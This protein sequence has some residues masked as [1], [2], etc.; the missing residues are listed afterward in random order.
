M[1]KT[2]YSIVPIGDG[3]HYL[4]KSAD[5]KHF[6]QRKDSDDV[7]G[8]Q[9]LFASEDIANDYIRYNFEECK[10]KAEPLWTEDSNYID[11]NNCFKR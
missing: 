11:K 5:G 8:S 10:Y 6:L 2:L 4:C 1:I 9:V 3:Y 7:N